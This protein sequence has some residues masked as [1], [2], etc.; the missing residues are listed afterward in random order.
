MVSRKAIKTWSSKI[1]QRDEKHFIIMV[2]EKLTFG[3]IRFNIFKSRVGWNYRNFLSVSFY[4]F[5]GMKSQKPIFTAFS[6]GMKNDSIF[7]QL[8]QHRGKDL[9]SY[10][11]LLR[12]VSLFSFLCVWCFSCFFARIFI[13]SRCAIIFQKWIISFVSLHILIWTNQLSTLCRWIKAA[14]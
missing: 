11:L 14:D 9:S 3:P 13:L 10:S 2:C 7:F 1:P 4:L 8:L 5:N 6:C 12:S